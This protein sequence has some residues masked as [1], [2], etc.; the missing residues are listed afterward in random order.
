M[1][2]LTERRFLPLFI[3]QFLG[4]FNDNLFKTA[5]AMMITFRFA[6]EGMP[7]SLQVTLASGVFILPFFLFS[8]TA[9]QLADKRDKAQLARWVKLAEILFMALGAIGFVFHLTPLLFVVLFLMGTHSA[10]FGPVK[11]ALLPQHLTSEELLAGNAWVEAGT[12]GA[13]LAGTI[14][15][16]LLAAHPAAEMAAGIGVIMTAILGYL[17]SRAIPPAPGADPHLK[18]DLHFWRETAALLGTLKKDAVAFRYILAISWF[19]L[20]GSVYLTQLPVFARDILGG[21]ERTVTVLLSLFTL[22]IAAGSF[23]GGKVLKDFPPERTAAAAAFVMAGVGL[24]FFLM[25]Q[26][27]APSLFLVA[28]DLFLIAQAGGIFAVPLYTALQRRAPAAFMS[29][30]IAGLNIV[31]AMAMVLSAVLSAVI[32]A[33]GAGVPVLFGLV[34]LGN[35]PVALWCRAKHDKLS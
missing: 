1:S 11:Y 20:A 33:A 14:L 34:A 27:F 6:A 9:G 8:A 31:N 26:L 13:I 32:L 10:F 24:H 25:A 28:I 3:T 18:I 29:R 5:M 2:L 15:G 12:F 4:A 17:S 22:G 16:G 7:S 23:V 35:I 21:D 30:T 19:W